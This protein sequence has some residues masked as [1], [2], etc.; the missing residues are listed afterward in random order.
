MAEPKV[1]FFSILKISAA[2]DG[3]EIREMGGG[4]TALDPG[5]WEMDF[6]KVKEVAAMF[7][8]HHTLSVILLKVSSEL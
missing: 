2:K 6:G 8:M 7:R 5:V 4:A 1:L 3:R